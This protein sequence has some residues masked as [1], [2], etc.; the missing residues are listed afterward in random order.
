MLSFTYQ[1]HYYDQKKKKLDHSGFTC[2][3]LL[4]IK[5][6]NKGSVL[7]VFVVVVVVGFFFFF[8]DSPGIKIGR[9]CAK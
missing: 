7:F 2:N 3:S 6:V 1:N 9:A 8:F 5:L 4:H